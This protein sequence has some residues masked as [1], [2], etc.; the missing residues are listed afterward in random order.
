MKTFVARSDVFFLSDK[1]RLLV[2]LPSFDKLF[3]NGVRLMLLFDGIKI[4][5]VVN[6]VGNQ[7]D[8]KTILIRAENSDDWCKIERFKKYSI[9]SNMEIDIINDDLTIIKPS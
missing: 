8:R 4:A 3:V 9:D 6:G 1:K 5:A 2:T 7:G